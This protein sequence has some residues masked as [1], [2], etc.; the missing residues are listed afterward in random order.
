MSVFKG[1]AYLDFGEKRLTM[2]PR[3]EHKL[4]TLSGRCNSTRNKGKVQSNSEKTGG[5]TFRGLYLQ[6]GAS[7]QVWVGLV[8]GKRTDDGIFKY[9]NCMSCIAVFVFYS[10][11][12]TLILKAVMPGLVLGQVL[13]S[14]LVSCL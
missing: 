8:L 5:L 13:Q 1:T 10:F 2:Y 11:S 6:S 7:I 12:F 14:A 3:L 9:V 4:L